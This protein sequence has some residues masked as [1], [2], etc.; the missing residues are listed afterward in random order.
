MTNNEVQL[1]VRG[2][3]ATTPFTMS[4]A[5]RTGNKPDPLI[6][7]RM[8]KECLTELGGVWVAMGLGFHAK[9]QDVRITHALWVDNLFLLA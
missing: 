2:A 8:L 4:R 3:A 7:V 1:S 5:L 9:T 6:F